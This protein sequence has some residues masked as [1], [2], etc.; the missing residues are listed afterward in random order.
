VEKGG[1]RLFVESACNT[2]ESTVYGQ[3]HYSFT[4]Q[5]GLPTVPAEPTTRYI[6]VGKSQANIDYSTRL[7][8]LSDQK[9]GY[10]AFNNSCR[11]LEDFFVLNIVPQVLYEFVVWKKENEAHK[12]YTIVGPEDWKRTL[13]NPMVYLNYTESNASALGCVTE[14]QL[15]KKQNSGV[16]LNNN[17]L[18]IRSNVRGDRVYIDG[19]YKGST[20]LDLSFPK[21]RHTIRIEKEGYRTHEEEIDLKNAL[22]VRVSL[23]KATANNKD[24]STSTA[25][26]QSGVRRDSKCVTIIYYESIITDGFIPIGEHR[27]IPTSSVPL[28]QLKQIGVDSQ[29]QHYVQMCDQSSSSTPDVEKCSDKAAGVK[30]WRRDDTFMVD[31]VTYEVGAI[32]TAPIPEVRFW[33]IQYRKDVSDVTINKGIRKIHQEIVMYAGTNIC[34]V[35]E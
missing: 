10:R 4:D 34:E 27:K 3:K 15:S 25:R 20:R 1:A 24:S 14:P 23:E 33:P 22:T 21:G 28:I 2:F 29:G 8:G 26:P 19:K 35:I 31:D 7:S 12:C 17:R 11:V 30:L 32:R 16:Q 13:K 9:D 6:A 18:T 5:D